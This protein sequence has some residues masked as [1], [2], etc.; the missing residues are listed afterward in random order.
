MNNYKDYTHYAPEINDR[1]LGCFASGEYL[2]TEAAS[3]EHLLEATQSQVA[4]LLERY[5]EIP[6]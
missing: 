2:V 4:Q 1:M 5:P 3:M 6:E